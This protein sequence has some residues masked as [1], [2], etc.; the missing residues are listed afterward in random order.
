MKTLKRHRDKTATST[1][2]DTAAALLADPPDAELSDAADEETLLELAQAQEDEIAEAATDSIAP[3]LSSF[4]EAIVRVQAMLDFA[5]RHERKADERVKW[6]IDWIERNMM[7]ERGAWNERRLLIFTEW[8]DTRLWLEKRLKEACSDTDRGDERIA[9]FTGISGQDKREKIKLA[10]NADP[11]KEPLRIL[12]CTDAAREGINLQTRCHDLIHFDLPWNPSRLE[13]WNGRI[14]RKLQPA[15]Y[16]TCRYFVYAQR[17]EDR[18]LAALVRKTEM[19]RDQLGSSGQVLADRIHKRLSGSGIAR[20]SADALAR[21]IE[22]EDGSASA[23]R[24]RQEMADEADRRLARL[25]RELGVLDRDLERARRR[26]G[27]EPSELKTVVETAL[28][29]EQVPLAPAQDFPIDGAF[30]ID[31]ALPAFAKDAT[32][33][34][35]FDELR[36]GRPPKAEAARGMAGEEAGACHRLQGARAARRSGCGRTCP[37][38]PRAPPCPPAPVAF[39]VARVQVGAEPRERHLRAGRSAACGPRWASCPLRSRRRP[40][41]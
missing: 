13:Q 33:S 16:V 14:D 11:G 28:L 6:L 17:P 34:D 39:R 23:R 18:V 21:E 15:E 2:T 5:Q 41:A 12:L 27:I 22:T 10:F 37:C 9:T 7:R 26:V 32:W 29:R 3:A 40:P 36:E 31:S 38:P 30:R 20:L 4:N 19:I 24:A 1:S 35:L 8:E 25:Q